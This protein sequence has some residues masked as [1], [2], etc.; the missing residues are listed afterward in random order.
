MSANLPTDLLTESNTV[1]HEWSLQDRFLLL[2]SKNSSSD[3]HEYRWWVPI[4]FTTPGG[5]FDDTFNRVWMAPTDKTK[6][7]SQLPSKDKA[8]IFNVQETG[9]YNNCT[10]VRGNIVLHIAH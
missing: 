5:N 6:T 7:I 1:S 2:R 3:S 9:T 8:V 4:T 10:E